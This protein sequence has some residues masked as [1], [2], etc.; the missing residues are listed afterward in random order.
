MVFACDRC[1]QEFRRVYNL[2][3]HQARKIR[4]NEPDLQTPIEERT[5]PHCAK[6]FST[7]WNMRAHVRNGA[8]PTLR[9]TVAEREIEALRARLLELETG[10]AGTTINNRAHNMINITVN[11]DGSRGRAAKPP[12]RDFGDENLDYITVDWLKGCLAA[13]PLDLNAK[14]AG[15]EMVRQIMEEIWANGRHPENLTVTLTTPRGAPLIMS[16]GKWKEAPMRVVQAQMQTKAVVAALRTP[17]VRPTDKHVL[18]EVATG[19]K[20]DE[21]HP[22][23]LSTMANAKSELETNYNDVPRLGATWADPDA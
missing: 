19:E 3:R 6:L 15:S 18:V 20:S 8:C 10:A 14:D 12:I 23:A 17:I 13:I 16:N 11:A 9:E 22:T 7:K 5:C 4:C 21:Y 1:G 2:R